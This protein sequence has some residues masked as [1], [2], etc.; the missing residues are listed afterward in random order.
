MKGIGRWSAAR[1]GQYRRK[2][3]AK[4]GAVCQVC[5]GPIDLTL[6]APDPQSF[7]IGH[8]IK[9]ADGGPTA[10]FNLRPEHRFCNAI[11][12]NDQAIGGRR[13]WVERP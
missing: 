7:T 5:H 9:E 3:I 2:L 6:T 1:R 10:V 8:V 12:S 13:G 4:F 11:A